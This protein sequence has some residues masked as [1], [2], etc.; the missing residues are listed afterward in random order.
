MAEMKK[1]VLLTGGVGFSGAHMVEH[2]L[3]ETDWTLTIIDRLTYAGNMNRLT[4]MDIWEKERQRVKFVYHDFRS[5]IIGNVREQVLSKHPDYIVH[6]GAETHVDR[7][8]ECPTPFVESNVM[9]TVN[10]LE[11]ARTADPEKFIYISTDEVYGAVSNH[12]HKEGEPHNPSN[13]YAASKSGAEA[14][15]RAFAKTYAVPVIIS[16]TM[17]L[18]GERQ[19]S[20]KFIPKTLR[21]IYLD[22]PVTIHC[23]L[24]GKTVMA[25]SSRCWLHA[26]NQASGVL[27]LLEHGA[28]GECYNV[29]GEWAEVTTIA[30]KIA[31]AMGKGPY[32][33]KYIDFHTGRP[34]HD[35]A[36]GLDGTKMQKMGWVPP[37]SLDESLERTVKWTLQHVEWM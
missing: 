33:R 10:M 16:N 24:Q 13:P 37:Y 34:G 6:A 26:R 27:F 29:V 35:M 1:H 23:R 36:Y 30:G 12:L 17:N 31:N 20:E 3:K 5:P 14:F 11:L 19:E 18:F 21:A 32:K 4:Q 15:C 7:S 22:Q 28:V 8:I 2:I 25:V 9:G